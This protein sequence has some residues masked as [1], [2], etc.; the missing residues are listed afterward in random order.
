MPKVAIVVLQ[1]N[2]ADYTVDCLKSLEKIDYPDAE[3]IVVDNN[4]NLSEVKKLRDIF[5]FKKSEDFFGKNLT[6]TGKRVAEFLTSEK[7]KNWFL[8]FLRD[9]YGF[10][11]GNNVGIELAIERG[12]EYV[13]LLNND[14]EVAPDF[15]DKLIEAGERDK[16]IG[17]LAPKIYYYSD[18]NILWFVGG[19]LTYAPPFGLHIGLD[20]ED[21]GQY[22][23]A[24]FLPSDF[25]TGCAILAK[26]EMIKKIGLMPEDYFL[27]F[28]DVDWSVAAKKAGYKIGVVPPARIW[29]KVKRPKEELE[30]AGLYKVGSSLYITYTY[31]NL[32]LYLARHGGLPQKFF[33]YLWLIFFVL[34][35]ATK[36]L[37]P[38]KRTYSKG[39]FKGVKM[40]F[41]GRFGKIS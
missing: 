41:T 38:S 6:K 2:N 12:A 37:I 23:K 21:K 22:D 28:E 39:F 5:L 13:L 34:K 25:L 20:E 30:S 29:H 33:T 1:W 24:N 19:K 36:L 11:G 17:M 40:Y 3:I 18:K 35:Q 9:N 27:Y 14:T 8:V 26:R 4:S 10:S 16:N 15:L 31:R 32:L 7:H